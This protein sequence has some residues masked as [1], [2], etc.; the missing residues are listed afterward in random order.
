MSGDSLRDTRY[1]RDLAMAA[2]HSNLDP[3]VVRGA[4]NDI[5][6]NYDLDHIPGCDSECAS[7]VIP[8]RNNGDIWNHTLFAPVFPQGGPRL[9]WHTP[10]WSIFGTPRRHP[11]QF[12]CC[13]RNRAERCDQDRFPEGMNP[14]VQVNPA[15]R[16]Q[17]N[18]PNTPHNHGHFN[19]PPV[20]ENAAGYFP[21]GGRPWSTYF[22]PLPAWQPNQ[23]SWTYPTG[24]LTWSPHPQPHPSIPPSQFWPRNPVLGGGAY[25]GA[26][27][28]L[29]P[30]SVARLTGGH[31]LPG[32]MPQWSPGTWP[33]LDWA[34]EVP[35]RLSPHII[36]N[37]NSATLAQIDWNLTKNPSTAKRLTANH[38]SVG[39]DAIR[40]QAITHPEAKKVLIVC[41]VGYLSTLWG[42]IVID[43]T[44]KVTIQ[45]L[46]DAI[47]QYFQTPLTHPEVEYI[48]RLDRSN[49]HVLED[50]Y[51]HRCLQSNALPGWEARQGLRRVDCLGDRKYWWGVW[52]SQRGGSWWLNLGL[53]NP[54]HRQP[55]R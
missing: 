3:R 1:W 54:A 15:P 39:L 43:Q 30:W 26:Y 35:V 50:A 12:P 23:Y 44:R 18:P 24:N 29:D 16:L 27:G 55:Q 13:R 32:T 19:L 6:R 17:W 34:N 28:Q 48:K 2:G 31:P 49:Y 20:G 4:F 51:R 10:N 37:P 33:P 8:D 21:G 14:G 25:A 45:D 47:Y 22:P 53:I 5:V 36:P 7:P 9:S 46:L 41:D 11:L 52:V 40:S 42:A 38:V